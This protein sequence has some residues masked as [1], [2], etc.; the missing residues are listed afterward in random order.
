[1]AYIDGYVIPVSRA[2]REAYE[3][4]AREVAPVFKECGALKVV[5]TWGDDVP[6]GKQ[7]DFYMA[8]KCKDDENVVFSWITWP[9]KATRDAGMAKAMAD[10]RMN[11][12]KATLPFDGAR[13]IL[14]GFEILLDE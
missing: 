2:N 9:D 1:M 5:E 10:P 14:G 4:L 3:K 8:V 6:R 11:P 13:M 7:T 12:D